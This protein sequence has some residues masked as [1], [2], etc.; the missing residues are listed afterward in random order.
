[1][2]RKSMKTRAQKKMR[3]TRKDK[4]V[5]RGRR[6]CGQKRVLKNLENLETN[7]LVFQEVAR[8]TQSMLDDLRELMSDTESQNL[9]RMFQAL[10]A[11]DKKT[12][13]YLAW[14]LYQKQKQK[15]H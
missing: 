13:A 2:P 15:L 1:M 11:I 14:R 12:V 9:V 4:D 10:S 5:P 6:R 7:L 3:K 8:S